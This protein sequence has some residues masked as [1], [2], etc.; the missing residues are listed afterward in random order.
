MAS[1]HD[2]SARV[3]WDYQ[4][5]CRRSHIFIWFFKSFTNDHLV[6]KVKN[7]IHILYIFF[8][9]SFFGEGIQR[10]LFLRYRFYPSHWKNNHLVW[11]QKQ[12]CSILIPDTTIYLLQMVE[13]WLRL[14]PHTISILSRWNV[15]TWWSLENASMISSTMFWKRPPDQIPTAPDKHLSLRQRHK[16]QVGRS[17]FVRISLRFSLTILFEICFINPLSKSVKK[18]GWPWSLKYIVYKETCLCHNLHS[19]C[20]KL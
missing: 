16:Q 13:A 5:L 15:W 8:F 3:F 18:A 10:K 6:P 20:I 2:A 7:V 4:L 9:K 1:L 14:P 11:N 19:C 17:A 12:D